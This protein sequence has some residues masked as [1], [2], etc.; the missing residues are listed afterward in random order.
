[1]KRSFSTI[2]L[3]L[4]CFAG[5]A[6]ANPEINI[7]NFPANPTYLPI[8]DGDTTPR[9]EDG[10]DFG[11]AAVSG[12][13]VTRTFRIK[14]NGD[15][16]LIIASHDAGGSP[17]FSLSSV[18]TSVEPIAPGGEDLFFVTFDPTTDGQHTT[19]IR[20]IN[21]DNDP[22]DTEFSYEFDVTGLALGNPEIVVEGKHH[23]L[24]SFSGIEY[25]QTDINLPE[26]TL[27]TSVNVGGSETNN[28][29]VRNIGDGTLTYSIDDGGSPHFS[30]SGAGSSMA[31]GLTDNFNIVFTPQ[32]YGTHEATITISNNDSNEGNY[33]FKVQGIGLAPDIFVRGGPSQATLVSDG[34]TTP[35]VSE[36]TDFGAWD[37]AAAGGPTNTFHVRNAVGATE[38]L[39]IFSGEIT[40]GHA[41]HFTISGLPA[42]GQDPVLLPAGSSD[43]FTVRFNPQSAGQKTATVRILSDDPDE[44]TYTFV[45]TG[46]GVTFPEVNVKGSK[47]GLPLVD[48][49]DGSATPLATNGTLFDNTDVGSIMSHPFLIE[50]TGSGVLKCSPPANGQFRVLG[51][52]E[53]VDPGK[54]SSFFVQFAP[55][56]QGTHTMTINLTTD[57]P[58]EN[59]YDF[60][61]R[62]TAVDNEIT[63][64]GGDAQN[65]VIVDG[66]TSV[67]LTDGTVFPTLHQLDESEVHTFVIRNEASAT[68]N[69]EIQSVDIFG[70]DAGH[71]ST[72]G[73]PAPGESAVS[74]APGVSLSFQVTFDPF[75]TGLKT[76][77]IRILSDDRDESPYTFN[78]AGN[79][80]N[81][82]NLRVSGSQDSDILPLVPISNGSTTPQAT[83]GTLFDTLELG[84]TDSNRINIYN[85]GNQ[86]L[87]YT[88]SS[89][90]PD[91]E[92]WSNAP[93]TVDPLKSFGDL[94]TFTPTSPGTKTATIT[95]SSN[96]ADEPSY[97]FLVRGTAT[98][99]EIDVR[100]GS[101]RPPVEIILS[102]DSTPSS[103]DGTLFGEVEV[104]G[105]VELHTFRIINQGTSSLTILTGSMEVG[106][107]FAITGI[108]A[109]PSNEIP[110][111][112]S[113]TFNIIFN[114]QWDGIHTDTV[115]IVNTD[116]DEPIFEFDVQGT[117]LGEPEISVAGRVGIGSV[118]PFQYMNI[119]NGL[120]TTSAETGTQFANT[121]VGGGDKN[122]FRIL[123]LG[124]GLLNYTITSDNPEFHF[125]QDSQWVFPDEFE[126][127]ILTFTPADHGLRT[128]TITITSNDADEN[129][130]TFQVSGLGIAE[131]LNVM[132]GAGLDVEITNGDNTPTDLKR[133]DFGD[134]LLSGERITREFKL[135]NAGNAPLQYISMTS[136]HGDFVIENKP[137][138][139]SY[140]SPA[141]LGEHTFTITY[142]PSSLGVRNATIT[143]LTTDPDESSYTFTVRGNGVSS[144][145]GP[146]MEIRGGSGFSQVISAGDNSPSVLKGTDLGVVLQGSSPVVATFQMKN[147]GGMD[148]A[149]IQG[150]S[151]NPDAVVSG[152]ASTLIPLATDPFTVTFTPNTPGVQT[153]IIGILSNDPNEAVYLFTVQLEVTPLNPEPPAITDFEI[154]GLD[155]NAGF[156]TEVGK[157]YRLM[158]STT[159]TGTWTQVPGTTPLAGTGTAGSIEFTI[160]PGTDPRRFYRL[161]VE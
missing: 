31:P 125:E 118:S 100:G 153:A 46:N 136:S 82:P 144:A 86:S 77:T 64:L 28:F 12:G 150:A 60:V 22:G 129:P 65:E 140:L 103:R 50:N 107:Q 79:G 93:N 44:A 66:T 71:F 143:I 54:E 53:S 67:S 81:G 131:D 126:Y 25:Q 98:A 120:M 161:E 92:V 130:Y 99:P 110:H 3:A 132:G 94:V 96:D 134:T 90:S 122:Q 78:V 133:T 139:A 55:T 142:D 158:S 17:H 37:I 38:T 95:I 124:D 154:S 74:I 48:V 26:G 42:P 111:G 40:G 13:V 32:D 119:A 114:P 8:L 156:Q 70:A 83:N 148:L 116:D 123:N 160:S 80:I 14:N 104:T 76:A 59:P 85:A 34:D 6:L 11:S 56:T 102:G 62:G 115:R 137:A 18:P 109:A 7:T 15:Q 97:S 30:I 106:D 127:D 58:N 43:P 10:T 157:T 39:K 128:A 84:E 57:D 27:F 117:G 88:I 147:A 51:L 108:P 159:M 87:V 135:V 61:V 145:T 105:G 63:V 9:L 68:K 73:A 5:V 113:L 19:T 16:N 20:I 101:A 33:T 121:E 49:P 151:G 36:G 47:P 2:V 21:N 75:G 146:E 152:V 52:P 23:T 35:S 138:P 4:L 41:S 112:A 69:L 29:R 24:G 89:S 72:S 45:V 91:F 1:M 149:G 155:G 141:P